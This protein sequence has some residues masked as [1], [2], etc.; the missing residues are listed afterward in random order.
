MPA[1]LQFPFR[2]DPAL[3]Q[4]DLARVAAGEWSA[5]YNQGDYRGLWRGAALR[6]VSG[7]TTELAAE[8]HGP[9]LFRDTPLLDRCPYFRQTL[10]AFP[11]PLRAVRLLSLAP[12]SFIREHVDNALDYEDG[13]IRIHV[14]IATNGGVEFYVAGERLLLQEGGCYYVDVNLPHRVNNRGGADRGS[15]GSRGSAG[16]HPRSLPG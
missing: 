12:G 5:H 2:F 3:L 16:S 11:C 9:A 1:G 15:P 4:A 6:S 10:S 13:E 8:T 14:P 7:A